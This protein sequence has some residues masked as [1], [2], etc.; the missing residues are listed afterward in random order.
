M[1]LPQFIQRRSNALI[2]L[3]VYI[4]LSSILA[5][6]HANKNDSFIVIHF[7][8]IL[9]TTSCLFLIIHTLIKSRRHFFV[10]I[11]TLFLFLF[12]SEINYLI[13][14]GEVI[15]E[16]VLDSIT[17]TN[18]YEAFSMLKPVLFITVP[19]LI[20]T[21][22]ILFIYKKFIT[23]KFR[24]ILPLTL[25]IVIGSIFI[26][27]NTNVQNDTHKDYRLKL[28]ILR[29]FY[30]AVLGNIVYL[31]VTSFSTDIYA[32]TSEIEV[33]NDAIILPPQNLNDELVVLIMGESSLVSRYSAYGYHKLTTPLM[34]EVFNQKN[35]G[36]IINNSHSSASFTRD[37]IPMTLSFSIP[38]SNDNLFNNKSIIEM[39]K[40]N[41]YKTY[42]LASY[43]QNI[44]GASNAKFGFIARKSD[45]LD[46][47]DKDH[48]V[49]L[50][51]LLERYLKK[52]NAPKKFIFIHLRGSH[53]PYSDGYDE[54][55]K[56]ALPDAEDY[57]L[58]IHHTDR[59][60][61]AIYDVI[62][63]YSRNYSI[64]YTSDHGEIVNL[65]H[66]MSKGI[67]QFL[68]P[69]MFISKNNQFDCQFIESYRGSN[70]YLSGL[71]NKY[72]LSN[73]LGYQI[74]QSI[75]DKEKNNDRILLPNH[76]N[77][78]FSD[79]LKLNKQP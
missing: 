1:K 38:E 17:E 40:Y 66:G 19:A 2:L 51:E 47:T 55:D 6:I 34:A 27:V 54:I 59:T 10:V 37:S 26:S 57:D 39:A 73:L 62:N 5:Y 41:N 74:D 79:Y 25:Y 8:L 69:F 33:F 71:M 77:V 13:Y 70:G 56:Q 18:S 67:D 28:L 72:I 16:G 78:I 29:E 30:P 60:V 15:S 53:Q 48:D 68:I 12:L 61:K 32:D 46:F 35:G 44:K 76:Q 36:C 21:V 9:S 45:I 24:P 23:V 75:L 65:G 43:R 49:N 22:G 50:S 3:L 42:W 64:I 52:D 14:F 7:L 31:G 58:T 11:G 4:F 20:V 63:K